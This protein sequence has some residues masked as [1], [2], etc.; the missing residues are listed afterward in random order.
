MAIDTHQ[1]QDADS[2][3]RFT[4]T[5]HF[6]VQ[7]VARREDDH[8]SAVILDF[9][10]AGRGDTPHEAVENAARLLGDYLTVSAREGLTLQEAR[11]PAPL[12]LRARLRAELL[13]DRLRHRAN[14]EWRQV[15]PAASVEPHGDLNRAARC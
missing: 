2:G 9:T 14:V 12:Q 15:L 13:W 4:I 3:S 8:W 6:P 7:I 5:E 11:R 10:I 1:P